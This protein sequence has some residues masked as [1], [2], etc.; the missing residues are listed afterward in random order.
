MIWQESCADKRINIDQTPRLY[1]GA[2]EEMNV[3]CSVRFEQRVLM[4]PGAIRQIKITPND[5]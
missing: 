1:S 5:R 2:R 3:E 4:W